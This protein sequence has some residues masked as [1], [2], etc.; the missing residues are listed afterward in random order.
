MSENMSNFADDMRVSSFDI[1]DTCLLRKCGT[2]ENFFDVL[3]FHVFNGEVEEWVRQEFVTARR[4]AEKSLSVSATLQDIWNAFSWT[5]PQLKPK[6]E[7]YSI[8]LDTEREMLVPVLKIREQV[9]KCRKHGDKII[10]ISDMHLSSEFLISIMRDYGFYQDGDSLYVSCECRADKWDGDLFLHVRDKEVLKSFRHWHHYG[11][12]KIADYKVPKKLGIHC[13]LIN[14]EY[15]PYQKQWKDNDY[16]LGFKYP[17]ILAGL[18]RALHLHYST[19]WNTHTDFVLDIIAPFYCSWMYQVLQD[20]QEKGI[21]RLYFCARDA[22]QIHKIALQMQPLF[23][24][25]SMEYVYISRKALYNEA[26]NEAKI[27]YFEQIGLA[28]KTDCVAIID[29]TTSGKTLQYLNEFLR[30]RGFQECTAYYYLLW[31]KSEGID[32]TKYTIEVDGTYIKDNPAASRFLQHPFIYIF[33]NMFSLNIEPKT[34][35]YR[36]GEPVFTSEIG[37][38]DCFFDDSYNWSKM[39]EELLATYTNDFVCLNLGRYSREIFERIGI[40]TMNQFFEVPQKPY[41]NALKSYYYL[42]N[43]TSKKYPVITKIYN[44]F[45]LRKNNRAYGWRRGSLY[46]SLPNWVLKIAKLLRRA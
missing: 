37:E 31:N 13:T 15:T 5:H 17:S 32:R 21:K 7:L 36:D 4:I 22:Y 39:H 44:P 12:N 41:I 30:S 26:N 33:E 23:P 14:F 10:F 43:K 6:E 34:I 1:F 45:K 24:K 42:E 19:E 16:S 2:P 18:G 29:T 3:S 38:E 9:N 8:E 27:A 28:T 35:D 25:V 40:A 11:D 20:A 46:Y